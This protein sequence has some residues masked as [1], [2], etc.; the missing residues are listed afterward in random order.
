MCH[1]SSAV[2][3]VL[4]LCL[5]KDLA[6]LEVIQERSNEEDPGDEVIGFQKETTKVW[7]PSFW[8]G[9]ISVTESGGGWV[10]W[11]QSCYWLG[12]WTWWSERQTGWK[13]S[14]PLPSAQWTLVPFSHSGG[15]GKQYQQAEKGRRQIHGQQVYKQTSRELDLQHP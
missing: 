12:P 2:C 13:A 3:A 15:E 4:G 5:K 11:T 14:A 9:R 1:A 10:S 6:E 7:D 8:P